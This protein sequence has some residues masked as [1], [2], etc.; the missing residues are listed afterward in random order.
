VAKSG[1]PKRAK[2]SSQQATRLKTVIDFSEI[3]DGL[4]FENLVADYFKEM[5]DAKNIIE[6]DVKPPSEG[7]DG[8]RDILVS[9]R[10]TDSIQ[11]FVRRWVVQCKFWK[12]SVPPSS[13]SSVNI[14]TLIHQYNAN[15]YLLV[16]KSNVTSGVAKMFEQLGQNCSMHYRYVIWNGEAF[17]SQLVTLRSD[18]PLLKKY[19]P[20]YQKFVKSQ[21]WRLRKS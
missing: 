19:F 7:S 18:S 20:A 8:G 16:C 12:N 5:K 13:L 1:L 17:K 9:F 4:H 10:F 14:P 21:E 15:G 11:S 3:S 6:V 2:K